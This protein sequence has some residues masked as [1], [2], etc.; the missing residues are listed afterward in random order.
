M[1]PGQIKETDANEQ[2]SLDQDELKNIFR[3]FD[4]DHSGSIDVSELADAMRILGV[5]CSAN[6]AKKVLS[7]IDSD[8]NGTVEWEEF[9]DFF[10]KVRNPEE[11]KN[12][13]AA[14]NQRFLD[15]KMMV[16]GDPNFGKRFMLPPAIDRLKKHDHN[17][18]VEGVGWLSDNEYISVSLDQE[19]K[20]WD[21]TKITKEKHPK[22]AR[23]IQGADHGFYSVNVMEGTPIKVLTGLGSKEDNVWLWELGND[24]VVQK[25]SGHDAPAYCVNVAPDNRFCLSGAK[26]GK[27]CFHDL[28]R[29]DPVCT[30]TEHESVVYAA[31]FNEDCTTILS[32]GSDGTIK[33]LDLKALSTAKPILEIEDAAATGVVYTAM[34]RKEYEI[35][36]GGDDY[37]VK[38]WDIRN[39]S[40]GPLTNYFGHTSA[41]RRVCMSADQTFMVSSTNDGCIRLWIVDEPNL[42]VEEMDRLDTNIERIEDQ[43]EEVEKRLDD[44][45]GSD[46]VSPADL[47]I[48]VDKLK[49]LY[50]QSEHMA[51]VKS[52]RDTL[53]CVQSCL[54]LSGHCLPV[55]A[56]ALREPTQRKP[57]Y[58][59]LCTGSQDQTT[60]YFEFEK[61]RTNKFE[62]WNKFGREET[63]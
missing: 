41:V 16:E 61:P 52:E 42:I 56:L 46:D 39:T 38:R 13:L 1:F 28:T 57:G 55:C 15:Y 3:M 51:A 10:S 17:D 7:V 49:D 37:C 47:K 9:Y 26:N 33:V 19:M 44:L 40:D 63:S 30:M 54:G 62:M 18:N 60:Q 27:V 24:T 36:S 34:W 45:D 11:I 25:Y 59:S 12:M 8:G 20:I 4:S 32:T 35:L 53:E 58:L 2:K 31:D 48:L 5:K 6:G 43:R 23:T 22:P 21:I 50:D 29:A 14:T